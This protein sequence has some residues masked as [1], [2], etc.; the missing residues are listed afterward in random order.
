MNFARACRSHVGRRIAASTEL[1]STVGGLKLS[2]TQ[3]QRSLTA[4]HRR[5]DTEDQCGA[6]YGSD[7]ALRAIDVKHTGL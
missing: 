3:V 7:V 1:N 5:G 4:R 2:T 6:R